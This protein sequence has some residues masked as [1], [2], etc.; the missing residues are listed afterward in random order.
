VGG[1]GLRR[2]RERG[3]TANDERRV[4]SKPKK[5]QR[6]YSLFQVK[7]REQCTVNLGLAA[8]STV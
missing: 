8:E 1:S 5:R 6:V 7:M 4:H 2:E 3:L